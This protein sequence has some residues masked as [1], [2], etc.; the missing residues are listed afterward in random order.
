MQ[1]YD[2]STL[3][4]IGG[5]LLML[6]EFIVP[7]GIIF[8]LGLGATL[9]SLLLYAGIIDGWLQA[10]TAWFIGSLALLFGLRSVVQ[11]IMP[12]EVHTGKTDEDIDAYNH[13][14]EVCE[15]IPAH[16]E[17]RIAFRG[18]TWVA[19]NYHENRDL[20]VGTPVRIIFRDNL[21]WL[22]EPYEPAEADKSGEHTQ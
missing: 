13:P 14:A 3:W 5:A 18:S 2:L 11:K 6:L 8:F 17:G 19:R 22:V 15:H 21:V 16:G 12:A 10:F 7:G 20:E 4:F 9:V 1:D